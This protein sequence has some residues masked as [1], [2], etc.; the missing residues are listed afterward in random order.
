ME[1]I[2]CVLQ[3]VGSL[4][5]QLSGQNSITADITV[6]TIVDTDPFM[7]EYRYEPTNQTQTIE[8]E[9][10]KA[11]ANIIIDPIPQNYGL[12]TWDG[13]TLTVS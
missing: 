7:G 1:R 2:S 6:P 12:I 9:G 10:L 5:G 4:I 3:D 13:S 11:T 8:I